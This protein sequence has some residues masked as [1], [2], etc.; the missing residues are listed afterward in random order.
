MKNAPKTENHKLVLA[1]DPTSRGFGYAVF[2]GP[3]NLLDWGVSDIRIQ[4][5]QRSKRRLKQLIDY[6]QPD[7]IV[8]EDYAGE[9]SHRAPR[10]QNLIEDI[11]SFARLKKIKF[12]QYSR[13]RVQ[14]LFRMFG[15]KNKHQIAKTIC[16]WLPTLSVRIPPKRKIWMSEDQRMNIF[17]AVSMALT[18]YY[19]EE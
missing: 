17:D 11:I 10:I 13:S 1:I 18:Y 16:E 2:E 8:L 12:H 5:N 14:E 3:K 6:Y 15:A 19:L 7:V 4:I 9:K